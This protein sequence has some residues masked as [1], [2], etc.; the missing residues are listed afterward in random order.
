MQSLIY[1]IPPDIHFSGSLFRL[2][3]N[4]LFE[5]RKVIRIAYFDRFAKIKRSEHKAENS[6]G[7]DNRCVYIALNSI[8]QADGCVL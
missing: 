6:V 7:E 2:F 5:K 8:A 4:E 3:F 1:K